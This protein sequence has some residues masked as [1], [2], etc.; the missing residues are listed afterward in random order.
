MD[1]GYFRKLSTQK[2]RRNFHH[3]SEIVKILF[4]MTQFSPYGRINGRA[5]LYKMN[6]EVCL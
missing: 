2:G 1:T 4:I 3:L 6:S 5:E